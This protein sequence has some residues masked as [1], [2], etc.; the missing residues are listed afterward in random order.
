MLFQSG[1]EKNQ[2]TPSSGLRYNQHTVA[3][4]RASGERQGE[5]CEGGDTSV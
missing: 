2:L 4:R 1:I 3:I 5:M